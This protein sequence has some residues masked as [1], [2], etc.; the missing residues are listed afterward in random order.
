V[1]GTL[2]HQ[3][4]GSR[5]MGDLGDGSADELDRFRFELG[6]SFSI[7]WC[8]THRSVGSSWKAPGTDA[9]GRDVIG[10]ARLQGD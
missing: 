3:K 10:V 7:R 6:I 1:R 8:I 9:L 5:R 4:N 2:M